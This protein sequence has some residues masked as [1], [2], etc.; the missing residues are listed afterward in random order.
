MP[1]SFA[2]RPR[3]RTAGIAALCLGLAS[4][5]RAGDLI[6]FETRPN[7]NTP[8]DDAP[9]L[10]P[11]DIDG[12]G[13][14]R[15]FFDTNDNNTFEEGV[16]VLPRFEQVGEDGDDG[17]LSSQ[18]GG[19]THDRAR[20]G[21]RSQLG[22]YFLRQPDGIGTLPGPFL[23]VYDT[24]QAIRGFS[25]EIWDIDGQPR[26]GVTEQWRV[27][28]LNAR[29]D[30]LAMLPSP[31]GVDASPGSLDSLPWNFGF[32]GLP[33]GVKAIRLTFT[34]TKGDGIGLAFNNFSPTFAVAGSVVP[35][36]ASV[37]LLGLGLGLAVAAP[38]LL[39]RR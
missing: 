30:V 37:V 33:D 4:A 38:A 12:G 15:F 14:V 17:F 3:I 11:Y 22:D 29:G 32:E 26:A 24:A 19:G 20:P 25:G 18:V 9:L 5:A 36:P 34:G 21:F 6:T 7:G 1:R 2:S 31:L 39:R 27:D 35:E 13:T 28:V 23:I 8:T 16:D 10:N